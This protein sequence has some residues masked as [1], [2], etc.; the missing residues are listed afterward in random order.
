MLAMEPVL[1]SEH[2]TITPN[3]ADPR[4]VAMYERH[5]SCY[6]YADGRKRLQ[7]VPPG[8]Y[9]ALMTTQL[10]ALFVWSRQ[11]YRLD[12]QVGVYCSVFRNE[13]PVLSSM[14]IREAGSLAL[15]RWP[16][17]RLFTFVDAERVR[18]TNPGCCFQMAGWRRCGRTSGGLLIYE[19][20]GGE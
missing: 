1:L 14:L 18:S 15:R 3:R 16:G 20:D 2:W 19:L 5:Y 12:D 10:D 9:L 13:G 6:Q 7:A 11:R 4:L 8:Q 17:Q